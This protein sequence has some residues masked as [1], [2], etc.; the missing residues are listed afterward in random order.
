MTKGSFKDEMNHKYNV[1]F[2]FKKDS[3]HRFIELNDSIVV[4]PNII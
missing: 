4:R 1:N 3:R 2:D